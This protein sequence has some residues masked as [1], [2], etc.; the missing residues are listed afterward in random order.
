MIRQTSVRPIAT[1]LALF[2]LI[3]PAVSSATI[4]RVEADGS[5]DFPT[6]QAAIDA[7]VADDVVLLGP[8]TYRALVS[9]NL[10]GSNAR[11]I[12][13]LKT[14]VTLQSE[15]GAAAT[16]LDGESDHHCL[17]GDGLASSTKVRGITFLDGDPSG[18]GGNNSWGGGILV[19]HSALVIED[20]VFRSCVAIGG[21][22]ILVY[23]NIEAGPTIRTCLF[24]D[25]HATDLGGAIEMAFG[26]AFLVE[27][28]TFVGNLADDSGGA[29]LLNAISGQVRR[30]I[31][32]SN[33]A[34]EG[35]GAIGCIGQPAVT[36]SCNL[37]WENLGDGTPNGE[38]CGIV[39]GADGNL[40][41]D[42]LFCDTGAG[43]FRLQTTSPGA[44]GHS[45][46]CGLIGALP[47]GCGP[48]PS[49]VG[50]E[51]P[52]LTANAGD[53]V[54]VPILLHGFA[55]P[56][57]ASYQAAITFNPSILTYV[58]LD[59]AGT[60]SEGML[61]VGNSPT[62]GTL[63][64]AAAG[65]E[66]IGNDA[67]LV[68]MVFAI[69]PGIVDGMRS[70]VDFESFTWGEGI[71][72]A[73]LANGGVTVGDGLSV[74]G[75]VSYYANA[76]PV[77]S[78]TLDLQGGL[79]ASASTDSVG[80]Y[81]FDGLWYGLGFVLT[82]SYEND[83]IDAVSSLDVSLVLRYLVQLETL[84]ARQRV[85][86]DITGDGTLSAEDASRILKMIVVGPEAL[87]SPLWLFQPATVVEDSLPGSMNDVDFIGILRGD[88]TGNWCPDPPCPAPAPRTDYAWS[89]LGQWTD[90]TFIVT[91]RVDDA[92][93]LGLEFA[94][95]YDQ[96]TM[97]FLGL[98]TQGGGLWETAAT[99]GR[100]AVAGATAQPW[101]AGEPTVVARFAPARTPP[102]RTQIAISALR[103]DEGARQERSVPVPGLSVR[104]GLVDFDVHVAPNPARGEVA[105]SIVGAAGPVRVDVFDVA[106]RR[107][108]AYGVTPDLDGKHT[109]IWDR[110]DGAGS[111]VANGI[112][113]LRA[114]VE[115]RLITRR[116]VL[117]Q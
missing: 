75:L 85:A 34:A 63:L 49:D 70:P 95:D 8:G 71:A 23:G 45:G 47:V 65:T 92:G 82:P 28:N 19:Y 41:T 43:D 51:I 58:R 13:F 7:A 17:V 55:P 15:Q 88:V 103:I 117:V 18:S 35:G 56:N 52:E 50:L 6:I 54:S 100:V 80:R 78:A 98:D 109:L 3:A 94:L 1:S 48:V 4:L 64:I 5:G 59:T 79:T 81:S 110:R 29:L 77:P 91:V 83:D 96:D 53:E 66:P 24:V 108:R 111:R 12:A 86:G 76:Y 21:G 33:E 72:P 10:N 89:S 44:P 116:I 36:G 62:P 32:W 14:G 9:R 22:A 69:P 87:P 113:F 74:R 37:F 61:V 38:G 97:R 2:M 101:T 40:V 67:I 57:I 112:Y 106:G 99:P 42:P 46:G 20:C 27:S 30:N 60:L 16:I 102:R 84:D 73:G 104:E 26:N 31:F 114:V 105:L 115:D 39:V 93:S 107:V 90:G 11:S 68:R 25:N